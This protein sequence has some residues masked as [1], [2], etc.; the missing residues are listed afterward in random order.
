M[1]S[2]ALNKLPGPIRDALEADGVVTHV[3][4]NVLDVFPELKGQSIA[5][6][7]RFGDWSKALGA[8]DPD[9]R[10]V[11]VTPKAGATPEGILKTQRYFWHEIGHH[12]DIRFDDIATSDEWLAVWS[13][14]LAKMSLRDRFEYDY[15][16]NQMVGAREAFAE[17]FSDVV[18]E[19]AFIQQADMLASRMPRSRQWMIDFIDRLGGVRMIAYFRVVNGVVVVVRYRLEQDAMVG[20]AEERIGPGQAFYGI[21][22]EQ[23]LDEGAGQIE[24]DVSGVA[25]LRRGLR[26]YLALDPAADQ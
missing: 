17:I 26:S 18:A 19:R 8:Y 20:D 12:V 6:K 14:D 9:T 5:D 23:L 7:S 2:G 4:N 13:Q 16:F 21:S 1:S 25:V 15:F 3:A 11:V 22:Y 24:V 10:T